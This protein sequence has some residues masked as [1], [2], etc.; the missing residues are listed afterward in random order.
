MTQYLLKKRDMFKTLE[1]RMLDDQ[2]R[3]L[4]PVPTLLINN[5]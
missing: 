3:K 5:N 2:K 4:F 1:N